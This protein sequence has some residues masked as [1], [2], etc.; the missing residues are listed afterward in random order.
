MPRT[1][2]LRSVQIV[3]R[4]TQARIRLAAR[5]NWSAHKLLYLRIRVQRHV[6]FRLP[7]VDRIGDAEVKWHVVLPHQLVLNAH[8]STVADCSD[9]S[10]RLGKTFRMRQSEASLLRATRCGDFGDERAP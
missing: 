5:H 4:R 7:C 9:D 3:Q 8:I 2:V 10:Q 1:H 6:V